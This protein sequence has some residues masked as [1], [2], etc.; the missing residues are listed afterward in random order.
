[1]KLINQTRTKFVTSKGPFKVNAIIDFEDAEART[2]LGY[3]GINAIEDLEA[4]KAP[5]KSE[6]DLLKEEAT[7]LGLE[8]AGNISKADLIALIKES[9]DAE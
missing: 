6:Y 7:K 1:M 2:L 9:K 5:K 8:F 3:E 4:N